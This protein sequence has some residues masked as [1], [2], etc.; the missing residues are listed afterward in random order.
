M[1]RR[2]GLGAIMAYA[3]LPTPASLSREIWL[4]WCQGQLQRGNQATED[5]QGVCAREV[6]PM[7]VSVCLHTCECA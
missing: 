5:L 3:T 2:M 6:V 1:L 4:Q 7:H